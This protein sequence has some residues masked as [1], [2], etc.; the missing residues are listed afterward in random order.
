[1]GRPIFFII[2]VMA[3][4]GCSSRLIERKS[5]QVSNQP[6]PHF[7]EIVPSIAP[8]GA[9][10]LS[11]KKTSQ[12]PSVYALDQQT[13]RFQIPKEQVWDAALNVLLKNYNLNIVNEDS[14][15]VT[16]EWDTFFLDSSV[17]RN[18]VSLRV[19]RIT[20]KATDVTVLNNIE[21]LQDG[22]EGRAMIGAVWLPTEDV[23]DEMKRII[24]NMSLALNQPL[25]NFY[26]SKVARSGGDSSDRR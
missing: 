22:S 16:T 17:Y 14:G 1:M 15:V 5:E 13:F 6:M 21:R 2:A 12:R 3:V 7:D 9:P 10:L 19:R 24:Q 20:R 25:P 4:A 26:D 11:G 23:A 18:K 8:M